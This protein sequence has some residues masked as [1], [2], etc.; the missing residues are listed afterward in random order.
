MPN[1]S[2]DKFLFNQPEKILNWHQRFRIIKGVASGLLYLHEEWEQVVLHRDIK[3][4]NVLLDG[5]FN[6]RLGDFG[7]ARLYDHGT[8]P[9][10]T[11]IVGTRGYIAPE[12]TRTGK[13]TTSTDVF[14][15]GVFVLEV[16]CGKRPIGL[17]GSQEE[18]KLVHWVLQCWKRGEIM[19]AK[20]ARLGNEFVKEEMELVLKLGL[21]CSQPKAEARPTMR[22]VMKFL[23]GDCPLPELSSSGWSALVVSAVKAETESLY[24]FSSAN[25]MERSFFDSSSTVVAESLLS[26]GRLQSSICLVLTVSTNISGY[27]KVGELLDMILFRLAL[28]FIVLTALRITLFLLITYICG[29]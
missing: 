10:T 9:Q 15:F 3:A 7:L 11:H 5:E 4:S 22:D 2:L 17:I 28:D 1:G 25:T 23:D 6:G 26:G 16:A 14:A 12:L 29:C 8:D 20:D 27:V 21:L 19:E 24:P 13:A 18:V